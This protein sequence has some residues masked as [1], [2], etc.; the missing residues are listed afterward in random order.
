MYDAF[1]EMEDKDGK[2][3]HYFVNSKTNEIG[4]RLNM[5]ED[6]FLRLLY[7]TKHYSFDIC[8]KMF[9]LLKDA[10]DDMWNKVLAGVMVW[11]ESNKNS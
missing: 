6:Y 11:L 5:N 10:D 1:V 2:F 7:E 9:E 8:N 3:Y 4:R